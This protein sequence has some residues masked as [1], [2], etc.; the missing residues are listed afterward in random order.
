MLTAPH[1]SYFSSKIVDEDEECV[2]KAWRQL[3]SFSQFGDKCNCLDA[4]CFF[5]II[6]AALTGTQKHSL[7]SN[8]LK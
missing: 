1:N 6:I 3:D 7:S 2:D 4:A 8:N 5:F